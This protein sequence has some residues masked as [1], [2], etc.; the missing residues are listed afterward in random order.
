MDEETFEILFLLFYIALSQ[1]KVVSVYLDFTEIAIAVHFKFIEFT[2]N[3]PL[4]VAI[5][6]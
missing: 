6:F 3:S 1:L 4:N 2:S 5:G